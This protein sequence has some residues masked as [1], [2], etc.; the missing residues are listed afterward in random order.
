MFISGQEM[1]EKEAKG[2]EGGGREAYGRILLFYFFIIF[3]S[4][5]LCY[6]F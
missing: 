1:D 6:L 4:S 3:P 2:E 5:S